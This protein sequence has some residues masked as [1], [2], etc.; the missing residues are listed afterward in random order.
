MKSEFQ[1]L[2]WWLLFG[3]THILGSAVPARTF[4]IRKLTLYGFKGLYSLVSF[5]TFIPLVVV[6]ARNKHA[7]A[8][9]IP[10]TGWAWWAAHVLMF[11]AFIFLFQG[12]LTRSPQTTAAELSGRLR[13]SARGIQRVTR[14]AVNLGFVLFGLAHMMVNPTVGDWIFFGGF[15]VFSVLATLHQDHRT[16]VAGA[17]EAKAFLRDTSYLPFAAIF[18]GRQKMALRECSISGLAVAVIAYAALRWFHPAVFGGFE[19]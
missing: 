18:A 19:G 5:A 13:G 6:Y 16:R 11:M 9:V 15:V 2:V 12:L 3:G 4:F 7:G 10:L 1:I 8:M 17:E 14:H